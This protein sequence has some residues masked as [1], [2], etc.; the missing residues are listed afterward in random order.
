MFFIFVD[1]GQIIK[2]FNHNWYIHIKKTTKKHFVYA[3][4][5]KSIYF[6]D[7]NLVLIELKPFFFQIDKLFIKLN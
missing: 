4:S 2:Y 5:L 7:N 3:F 6:L 1:D